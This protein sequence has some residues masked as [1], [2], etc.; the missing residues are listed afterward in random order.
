MPPSSCSC[1]PPSRCCSTTRPWVV[2][3]SRDVL[4]AGTTEVTG[5]AA[6]PGVVGLVVVTVVALLGLMTGGR[7]IR[8]VSGVVLVLAAAGATAL[9]LLVAL[10][11]VD[12]VSA[13]VAKELARTTAPDATGTTTG[14][15]WAAVVVMVALLARRRRRSAVEPVVG[16]ACRRATSAAPGPRAGPAGRCAARG[17][18]S[19]RAAT[20]PCE[21]HPTRPDRMASVEAHGRAREPIERGRH[22]QTSTRTT[23]TAPPRG[24]GSAS[25]CSAPP[26]PPSPCSCPASLLGIIGAA[27]IIAGAGAGKVLS[28]AG[29]G[30][31]GPPR[32]GR[33]ARRR[34]RRGG[35]RDPRQELRAVPTV[36]DGIIDG[37]REDLAR[38]R[39]TTSLVELE[40]R[41]AVGRARARPDAGHPLGARRG[42]H[43]RGQAGQPQ[44][45]GARRDPRARPPRP[46]VCRRGSERDQRAHG[47]A[48]IQRQPRRPRRGARRGAD[49][50]AAQG[51]HGRALPGHRGPGP[52]RRPH[53]AHRRGPR[54]RP[55]ARP[56]RP[57]P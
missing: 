12:A 34:P 50:L 2:G 4:S 32:P 38:R 27:L 23:D 39:A 28:M 49:S 52:R 13:A 56:A 40:A 37:V 45:G 46:G 3:E 11:P 5:S 44:Q 48:P 10:R 35:R 20:P 16:R 25:S 42:R 8:A 31:E 1:P 9:T 36:L 15:G 33:A 6:A 22:G 30:S 54:R 53:P 29:Y 51:L 18:S 17:T 21:T 24:P 43:R 57:G 41:L 55:D 47:G 19:P 7:I 14:W 26:S